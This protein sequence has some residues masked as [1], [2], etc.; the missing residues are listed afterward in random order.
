MTTPALN[1][2]PAAVE[3]V[4]IVNDF[5][6]A[7]STGNLHAA[8]Q[9]LDPSVV[10][11]ANSVIYGDRD[12]YLKGSARGDALFLQKA[13]RQLLRRQAR[14]G[15]TF[16]WVVSERMLRSSQDGAPMAR[17]NTETMLL[18]KTMQG[19]KIV[20]INWSSRAL[21]IP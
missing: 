9:F 5:M 13:Q 12:A 1:I 18:A 21:A 11:V 4:R 15:H 19:W 16:A 8:Q 6:S 10:V 3:A 7:F 20:H 14:A 17:V 2:A